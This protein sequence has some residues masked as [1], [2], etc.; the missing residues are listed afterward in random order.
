MCIVSI[1]HGNWAR[2]SLRDKNP[3]L[4]HL[5]DALHDVECASPACL[6][7]FVMHPGDGM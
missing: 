5:S 7:T 1:L 2:Q 6:P 3:G 4:A